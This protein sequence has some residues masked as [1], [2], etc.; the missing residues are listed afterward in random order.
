[1]KRGVLSGLWVGMLLVSG[2]ALAQEGGYGRGQGWSVL[3]GQTVGQG[4]NTL[5]GQVGWPGVSLGLLHGATSR[6]DIGGKLSFNYGREGIVSLVDPGFKLQAWMRLMLLQTSQVNVALTFAPGPFF[7]F[8]ERRTDVGLALPVG[9]TLGLPVGSAL[10]VNV[11]IDVPFYVTFGDGGGPVFPLLV[12]GG[13]EY[14]VNNDLAVTFN[15]RMGPSLG[16]TYLRGYTL[17]R[18]ALFTL[19]ATIGVAYRL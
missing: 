19:D 18:D 14:F 11:G 6:F 9:F 7:Y 13:L 5:V 3:A 17:R 1:M 10:M 8:Y 4:R 12:G 16:A 15:V 2:S